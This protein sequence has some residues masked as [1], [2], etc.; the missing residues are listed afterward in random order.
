MLLSLGFASRD[1]VGRRAIPQAV[2]QE[3]KRNWNK[4]EVPKECEADGVVSMSGRASV[5]E[6]LD[7]KKQA[8][9][10]ELFKVW[11]E[12]RERRLRDL[13]WEIRL[14][15]EWKVRD[16]LIVADTE[17]ETQN[18]VQNQKWHPV[19][20]RPDPSWIP[21]VSESVC[22]R[23]GVPSTSTHCV[24]GIGAWRSTGGS[25]GSSRVPSPLPFNFIT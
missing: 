24:S 4:E 10:I 15:R 12:K 20:R 19:A 8:S 2:Q 17:M 9:R 14:P 18:Q 13:G 1:S 6:E 21:D 11:T 23:P 5:N 22:A 16:G 25:H 3:Q 7:R